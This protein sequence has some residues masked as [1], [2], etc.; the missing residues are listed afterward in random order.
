MTMSFK[1]TVSEWSGIGGYLF[2]YRL[3]QF[4]ISVGMEFSADYQKNKRKE[5]NF[6]KQTS[7]KIMY[8]EFLFPKIKPLT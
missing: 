1:I 4:L 5:K 8:S 6:S 7:E 2:L 3:C